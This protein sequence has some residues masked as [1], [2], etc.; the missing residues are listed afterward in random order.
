MRVV[1]SVSIAPKVAL[2]EGRKLVARLTLHT[3][4]VFAGLAGTVA[5]LIVDLLRSLFHV[6]GS[7]AEFPS[8]S[9]YFFFGLLVVLASFVGVLLVPPSPAVAALLLLGAGIAFFFIV[10]WWALLASPFLLFAAVLILRHQKVS[11][12]VLS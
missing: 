4:T 12:P 10:G 7:T 2:G 11:R 5:A 9:S 8:D 6:L 1:M 3:L